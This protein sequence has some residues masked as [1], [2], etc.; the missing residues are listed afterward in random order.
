RELRVPW[1]ITTVEDMRFARESTPGKNSPILR[2]LQGYIRNVVELA[3][4][5]FLAYR[6]FAVILHLIASPL[7]LLHPWLVRKVL[8]HALFTR[9]KTVPMPLQPELATPSGGSVPWVS[10][11]AWTPISGSH[12][13][14]TPVSGPIT[15]PSGITPA[16]PPSAKH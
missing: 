9:R 12:L 4:N 11:E 10:G 5:D 15:P 8:L 2:F 14:Q 1:L 16:A 13:A 6:T 3:A 7:R